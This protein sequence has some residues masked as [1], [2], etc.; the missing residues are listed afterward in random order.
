MPAL[1][2]DSATAPGLSRTKDGRWV[3]AYAPICSAAWPRSTPPCAC[4]GNSARGR[5]GR[6]EIPGRSLRTEA[7]SN[8]HIASHVER[9][10]G[11]ICSSAICGGT[12]RTKA[13]PGRRCAGPRRMP[14]RSIGRSEEPSSTSTLSRTGQDLHP[15]RREMAGAR[16]PWR[17]G[18]RAPLL[19][20]HNA[21]RRSDSRRR[22]KRRRLPRREAGQRDMPLLSKHGKP[23]ALSGVRVVDLGWMLASAGAGRYLAALGAE[24]IK[25]EHESRADGMRLGCGTR[26]L[27][28][29]AERR[30]ATGPLPTPRTKRA[31]SQRLLHGDQ[32]RQ[33]RLSLDLKKPEGKESWRISS[34]TPTWCSRAIRRERWTGWDW[35]TIA[36]ASSIPASSICSSRVRPARHLWPGPRLRPDGAGVFRAS[37]TCPACPNRVRRPAS[38]TPIS[39]GSARTTW[40]R[41]ALAA[42]YRRATTGR[43]CHVDASQAEVGIFLTGTAFSITRSMAAA[44]RATAT[45]RPIGSPRRMAP[46][47][48]EATTAG[49]PS[50]PSPTS[51][52]GR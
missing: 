40:R 37:A 49:S 43:G 29:R 10:V 4:C 33:A 2:A 50:P 5:S 52:G 14:A 16:M 21:R 13:C 35:A 24:V 8:S 44:G 12:A 45:V 18:P 3:L 25:V 32:R 9:L 46:T 51:S 34:A 7:A 48:H 30:A 42:L 39:T 47:A 15:G 23:F 20:E 41:R 17:I 22:H 1:A 19:G 38:A 26:P 11:D 36:C 6:R 31:Q 28:G 27:G